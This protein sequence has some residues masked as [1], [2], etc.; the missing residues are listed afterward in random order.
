MGLL[1]LREAFASPDTLL[2]VYLLGK[3]EFE[4]ALRLQRRLRDQAEVERRAALVLC[5]HPPLITVGRQGSSAHLLFDLDDLRVRRWPVRWVNRGGGCV[6]HLPGQVVLYAVVPLRPLGLGV[7]DH[8]DRLHR[9]LVAALDDFRVHGEVRP[10][11][12]GVRVGHRPVAQVGVAVRDW[13]TYFGAVLNVEPDLTPFRQVRSGVDGDGPMTS[14]ARERGGPVR[15]AL[16]RQ[17]LVE[18]FAAAYGC[19]PSSI[20]F[21]DPE[22]ASV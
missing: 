20:F 19:D 8:L 10:D 12:A 18:H 17:R 1:P 13:I 16:V 5:E 15:M 3:V 7:Q 4:A 11:R 2:R 14:L 9:V 22:P 6:L 21:S